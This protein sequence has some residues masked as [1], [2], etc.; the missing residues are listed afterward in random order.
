V[1]L[2]GVALVIAERAVGI[3]WAA[4]VV[5]LAWAAYCMS[6]TKGGTSPDAR[7]E[8]HAAAAADVI[9]GELTMVHWRR[10]RRGRAGR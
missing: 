1:F 4:M 6:P 5:S 9:A 8:D 10:G 7:T 3:A 2:T